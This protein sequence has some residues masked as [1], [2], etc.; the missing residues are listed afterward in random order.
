MA[1]RGLWK[2]S[3]SVNEERVACL[4]GHYD[5]EAFHVTQVKPVPAEFADSLRASP[6]AS[7]EG[8]APPQWAG[9]VHTHIA[10]YRGQPYSTF[11]MSDRAVMGMWRTRWRAEGAFCVLYTE[12]DA[13]CE[14]GMDVNG[15]VSYG[16]QRGNVIFP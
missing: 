2:E 11:S 10:L 9:T 4:G 6:K 15:D 14:Y 16:A 3:V 1:L 5:G 8:C 7:L 12:R 13:Y